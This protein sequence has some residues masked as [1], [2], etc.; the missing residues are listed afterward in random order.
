MQ[1]PD[2]EMHLVQYSYIGPLQ[3]WQHLTYSREVEPGVS[4]RVRLACHN[5]IAQAKA[6]AKEPEP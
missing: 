5:L 3:L 1:T 4:K 2:R 6:E